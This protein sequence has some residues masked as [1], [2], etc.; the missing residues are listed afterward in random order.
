MWASTASLRRNGPGLR[1]H[2]GVQTS[3][4]GQAVMMQQCSV[5]P[6]LFHMNRPVFSSYTHTHTHRNTH[7]NRKPHTHTKSHTHTKPHIHTNTRTHI[8]KTA[9]TYTHTYK[10]THTHKPRTQTHT[11]TYTQTHTH[12]PTEDTE[13]KDMSFIVTCGTYFNSLNRQW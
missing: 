12:K 9:H 1:K 10:T 3:G 13:G 4:S 8:H 7:T 5:G 11:Q 6:Q 2:P